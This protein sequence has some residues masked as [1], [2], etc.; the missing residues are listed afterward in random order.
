MRVTRTTEFTSTTCWQ[1]KAKL[2]SGSDWSIR[3]PNDSLFAG[4]KYMFC[5]WYC[6]AKWLSTVASKECALKDD[7]EAEA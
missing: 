2:E 4:V 1:C 7:T 3:T 5:G 6:A